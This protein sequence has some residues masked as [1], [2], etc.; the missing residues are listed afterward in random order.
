M[1]EAGYKQTKLLEKI[2]R[3]NSSLEKLGLIG[4]KN[5]KKTRKEAELEWEAKRPDQEAK[6]EIGEKLR[7]KQKT[8][9]EEYKER[10]DSILPQISKTTCWQ[11]F[12]F[13]PCV[14]ASTS[15][16]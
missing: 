1:Q 10:Q 8:E 15:C 11:I 13:F 5:I 9:K 3:S 12:S 16:F 14:F 4:K 6:R 2:T 7:S